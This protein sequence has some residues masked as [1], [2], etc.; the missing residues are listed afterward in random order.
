MDA[1]WG[2]MVVTHVNCMFIRLHHNA[3]HLRS[4]QTF[5]IDKSRPNAEQLR[6]RMLHNLIKFIALLSGLESVCAADGQ[7][8]LQA[9]VDGIGVICA[10]QLQSQVQESRPFPGEV[11]LQDFLEEGNQLVTDIGWCRR[12]SGNQALPEPRLLLRGD[13]RL[14]VRGVFGR[15]PSSGDAVLQVNAGCVG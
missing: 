10:Q 7:Q 4:L 11:V 15:R 1:N 13:P 8:T 9:R 5:L 6:E 12:E 2:R 3:Q 14:V